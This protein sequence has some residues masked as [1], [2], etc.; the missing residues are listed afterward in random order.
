M[1]S[2]FDTGPQ[3]SCISYECYKEFTLKTK[4]N[5]EVR[6][7]VS[8]ADGS[9]LGPIGTFMCSVT[10]CAHEFEDKFIVCRHLLYPVVLGLDFTKIC[11]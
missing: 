11:E 3:V 4:V 8:S 5:T 10:Y 7:R 2:L 1:K 6:T 9:N